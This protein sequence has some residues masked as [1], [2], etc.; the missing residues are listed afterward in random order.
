MLN[1]IEKSVAKV[2]AIISIIIIALIIATD[3][4]STSFMD[5]EEVR[6]FI[7]FSTVDG[8]DDN[9]FR[10]VEISKSDIGLETVFINLHQAN[11]DDYTDYDNYVEYKRHPFKA[12]MHGGSGFLR[13]ELMVVVAFV[14]LIMNLMVLVFNRMD[15]VRSKSFT[16]LSIILMIFTFRFALTQ[17]N[18]EALVIVIVN[19][20][21]PYLHILFMNTKL[22]PEPIQKFLTLSGRETFI[23]RFWNKL[24]KNYS[25]IE[26]L[27][28]ILYLAILV[29][30][31][32]TQAS[33]VVLADYVMDDQEVIYVSD[34]YIG[35]VNGFG[36]NI[37]ITNYTK[38]TKEGYKLVYVDGLRRYS[39]G[40][41]ITKEDFSKKF[42]F[43]KNSEIMR[44]LND[45]YLILNLLLLTITVIAITQQKYINKGFK[46][47]YKISAL[48]VAI[49][50]YFKVYL[51]VPLTSY[52]PI[53]VIGGLYPIVYNNITKRLKKNS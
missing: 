38:I 12:L 40:L 22:L 8:D 18:F 44:S 7:D 11:Q 5:G 27:I 21:L 32:I 20:M 41:V 31:F 4:A 42:F 16:L 23:S 14:I 3:I 2:S 36:E 45:F 34:K 52:Y 35:G 29:P 26:K 48:I 10:V 6:Y 39:G 37:E 47:P 1:K 19:A 33:H 53:L 15:K 17:M 28:F 13:G 51:N 24:T 49:S 46:N 30:F 25:G 9:Y 43:Y 50:L